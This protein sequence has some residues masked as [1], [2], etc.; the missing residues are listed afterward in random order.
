M[1]GALSLFCSSAYLACSTI[2]HLSFDEAEVIDL[3][4]LR[5][6]PLTEKA[7]LEPKKQ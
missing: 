4:I 3:H 1:A 6:S 5:A 2:P 7:F